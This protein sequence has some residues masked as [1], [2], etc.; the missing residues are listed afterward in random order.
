MY[1]LVSQSLAGLPGAAAADAAGCALA[2]VLALY[3][4]MLVIR[5]GAEAAREIGRA[6]V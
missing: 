3:I 5:H 2:G 6:H 4:A 1:S